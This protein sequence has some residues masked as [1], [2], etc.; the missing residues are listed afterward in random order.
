VQVQIAPWILGLLGQ[1][2]ATQAQEIM[3]MNNRPQQ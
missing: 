1:Q 3:D 2:T